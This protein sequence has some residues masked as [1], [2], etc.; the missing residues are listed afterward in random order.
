MTTLAD[1]STAI[2]TIKTN[3]QDF[4]QLWRFLAQAVITSFGAEHA[5]TGEHQVLVGPVADRPA[6]GHEGH[7]FIQT[8]VGGNTDLWY[9]TGSSWE[10]I[11]N[12]E[13]FIASFVALLAAHIAANPIEHP[14]NSITAAKILAGAILKKHLDGSTDTDSIAALVD[15]TN[16]DALHIHTPGIPADILP[17]SLSDILEGDVLLGYSPAIYEVTETNYTL[18]KK[19]VIRRAGVIKIQFT[20]NTPPSP[21]TDYLYGRLYINEI[22]SGPEHALVSDPDNAQTQIFTDASITVAEND[23]LEIYCKRGALLS[24]PAYVY[25]FKIFGEWDCQTIL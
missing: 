9:D 6:F 21:A 4:P 15:G 12:N 3:P 23:R 16:A 18:K 7:L 25:D 17:S 19:I 1:V 14:D 11:T 2:P 20:L 13:T 8:L 24:F 10:N 5:L 22:F